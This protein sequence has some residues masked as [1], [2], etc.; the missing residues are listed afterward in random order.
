[1]NMVSLFMPTMNRKEMAAIALDTLFKNTTPALVKEL[2]IVD[3][4]SDDGLHEYLVHR[5]AAPTPFPARLVT[6]TQ[7]HVVAAM[8]TGYEEIR[9]ALIAKVDSDT[10]VPPQ[11]LE[12][13]LSPMR[14]YDSLW[15]LGMQAWGEIKDVSPEER[16][17]IA[18]EFVGGIGL[19][20]REAWKGLLPL[21]DTYFGWN[22]HQASRPWGKGWLNPSIKVFL[23]DCLPFEPFRTL[24]KVYREKGWHRTD[25]EYTEREE[26]LWS[27]KYP[28]WKTPGA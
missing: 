27:W 15:V 9:S 20:R 5:V 8:Q 4:S 2:V 26:L 18:A 21:G 16:G 3:G 7:R 11:W 10:M 14:R 13:L 23:L 6:I 1:M 25:S 12:A 28:N 24:R 22:N 19:F 17:F